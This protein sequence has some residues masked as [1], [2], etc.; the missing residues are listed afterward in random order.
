MIKLS[1]KGDLR[2]PEK[3][4]N[5]ILYLEQRPNGDVNLMMKSIEDNFNWFIFRLK[6]DGTF[7][8]A[9]CLSD[10]IGLRLDSSSRIEESEE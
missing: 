9:S 4:F 10:N 5:G 1:I 7:S 8:R 6:T 3:E 2:T